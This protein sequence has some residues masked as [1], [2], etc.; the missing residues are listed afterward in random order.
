ME[1]KKVVDDSGGI[2]CCFPRKGP[3]HRSN[4]MSDTEG[5]DFKSWSE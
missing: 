3:V 4:K 5:G 1:I 2:R